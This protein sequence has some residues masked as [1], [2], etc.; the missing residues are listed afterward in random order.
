MKQVEAAIKHKI[1]QLKRLELRVRYGQGT[2]TGSSGKSRKPTGQLPLLWD[3]FFDLNGD[4]KKKARYTMDQIHG[5]DKEAYKSMV[6]EFLFRVYYRSYQEG[7]RSELNL[8]DPDLLSR[9]GLPFDADSDAVKR[10][11]RELAKQYHPDAGGA[12]E[13]FIRLMEVYQEIKKSDA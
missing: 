9:L 2:G 7:G 10:R 13:E 11:F 12:D 4:G 8:Y 3:E 6:S 5:M 1:R